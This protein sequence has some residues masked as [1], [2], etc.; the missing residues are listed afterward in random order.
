MKQKTSVMSDARNKALLQHAFEDTAKGIGPPF[1]EALA[2]D[3]RWTIIGTTAWSGIYEGNPAVVAELLAPLAEQ[4]TAPTIRSAGRRAGI[5]EGIGFA[6]TTSTA[7]H[8]ALTGAF[9]TDKS[10]GANVI[11]GDPTLRPLTW[12]TGWR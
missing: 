2:D 1:V 10:V 8:V 3:V 6:S 4:F 9:P 5:L 7:T 12:V 11:L